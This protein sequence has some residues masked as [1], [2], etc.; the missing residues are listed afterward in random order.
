MDRPPSTAEFISGVVSES[1]A[2]LI[3]GADSDEPQESYLLRDQE[4]Q[5]IKLPVRARVVLHGVIAAKRSKRNKR[6]LVYEIYVQQEL[7]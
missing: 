7:F 6:I 1:G 4:D 3:V 2:T 5:P